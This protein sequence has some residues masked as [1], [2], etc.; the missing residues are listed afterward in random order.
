MAGKGVARVL[1]YSGYVVFFEP[2]W[3][4]AKKGWQ[5]V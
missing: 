2:A 3:E 4:T 1:S 5:I